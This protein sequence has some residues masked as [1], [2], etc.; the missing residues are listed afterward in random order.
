MWRKVVGA[1]AVLS[2]LT[3]LVSAQLSDS[4][5]MPSHPVIDYPGET[6]DPVAQLNRKLQSGDVR[7]EDVDLFDDLAVALEQT[8]IAAAKN[9][10]QHLS[11][12]DG[13][14]N[15]F[16]FAIAICNLRLKRAELR[17]VATIAG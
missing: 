2:W 12:G 1:L 7:L 10:G 3:A 5:I 14:G 11:K 16:L 4:I 6:N 8:F 17:A 13:H 9:F 15:L